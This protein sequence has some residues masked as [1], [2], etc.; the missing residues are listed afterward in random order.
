MNKRFF[1]LMAAV[2]LAGAPFANEAFAAP[3]AVKYN[4]SAQFGYDGPELANGVRFLI[5]TDGTKFVT[6]T[7]AKA[8]DGAYYQTVSTPDADLT[9]AAV[10]EIR[11]YSKNAFGASFN[12]YVDGKMFAV[13]D[14]ATPTA[15]GATDV[16]LTTFTADKTD[17]EAIS[18]I[19]AVKLGSTTATWNFTPGQNTGAGLYTLAETYVQKEFEEYNAKATTLSFN[20]ANLEGN[21]FSNLQPVTDSVATLVTSATA[22]LTYFV[23]GGSNEVAAFKAA[24]REANATSLPG[25][26]TTLTSTLIDAVKAAAKKVNFVYVKNEQYDIN[27]LVDGE[28]YKFVT[29]AGSEFY[30]DSK[31]AN[32]ANSAFTGIEEMDKLNAEGELFITIKPSVGA[33]PTPVEVA[34]AA[35][36][37]SATDTKTYVTTVNPDPNIQYPSTFTPIYPTLGANTYFAASKFL[38]NQGASVY[39]IYFTSGVPSEKDKTATEYHK[40]L[41]QTI[42]SGAFSLAAYAASE[43]DLSS[44]LAQWVVTGFNNK[45]TLTL[46]N[47]Q[48]NQTL[49]LRL[50]ATAADD[51]YGVN[52]TG[53]VAVKA[54]T[55]TAS[56]NL[57]GTAIKLVPVTT[58]R[59]DG[60]LSLSKEEMENGVKLAFSGKS[61]TFGAAKFYA[62]HAATGLTPSIDPDDAVV[63]AMAANASKNLVNEIEYAYIASN[64]TV[65]TKKDT[66]LVAPAYVLQQSNANKVAGTLAYNASGSNYIFMKQMDGTYVM[67]FALGTYS[68]DL[69]AAAQTIVVNNGTQFV[70]GSSLYAP[71]ATDFATVEVIAKD[72]DVDN[73]T[74][75]AV[76]RH[77]AFENINGS[78]AV[79][80][81][82]DGILEGVLAAEPMTFW[83]DTANSKNVTPAFYI[84]LGVDTDDEEEDV[85]KAA[86]PEARLFMYFPKDSAKIFNEATAT[87]STNTAYLLNGTSD[88]K[89][90][91]RPAALVAV[92]TLATLVGDDEVLVSKKAKAGVCKAG[93]E[94]FQFK[95]TLKDEDIED[96]YVIKPYAQSLYLYSQNGV[97]GFTNDV[98]KALVLSVTEGDPT[99]NEA[100]EAES[101][102]EVIGG[103]G[104]VTVQGA[105]G[106]VITVANILGQTIANQVAASDNV[107]IAAPAGIVVVSVDGEATKVIVK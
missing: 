52:A 105:A 30:K 58:S 2:L 27:A 91:F 19:E 36:K 12:L 56:V 43:V 75:P 33:T 77:A 98:K 66:L 39:N 24:V 90:I 85:V 4:T 81:N 44:P 15:V 62:K 88:Y 104:V 8:K 38:K 59:T 70:L 11:K 49:E 76:S 102:I 20:A 31:P 63:L 106:K 42:T 92:D 69:G 87:E 94:N 34:L 74:L 48:T 79:Q 18:K 46:Q 37:P 82:K 47:R 84:S 7:S 71:A 17:I 80:L 96:E 78:V 5:S 35:I 6:V 83:L 55:K 45:Y 57:G 23:S 93:I 10:F 14:N 73:A 21:V 3:K 1:T 25:A 9:K 65:A 100:I 50:S 26:T 16:P 32:L 99:A 40:Y 72:A 54:G 68:T 61:A 107:T 60:F 103:Q 13:Q 28:G 51:V 29:I 97:L 67:R 86:E 101:G 64:G 41:A 53:T 95:I 89:A 22:P